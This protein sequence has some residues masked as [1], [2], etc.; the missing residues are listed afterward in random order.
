MPSNISLALTFDDVLLE[1]CYSEIL[2]TEVDPRTTLAGGIELSMPIISAAM[3]TVT[4]GNLAIAI[5]REG[6]LG[7]IHKN[8]SVEEQALEVAK[9]K[10]SESGM[11]VDP[12][13][14][15][16]KATLADARQLMKTYG[17]SGIPVVDESQKLVGILTNR[18]L[19]FESREELLVEALMTK[20]VVT[21]HPGTE[22]DAAMKLLHE[23][24][25]EKLPVVDDD[26]RLHGL[27]TIKDIEKSENFP[28]ATKDKLGRLR[29][30]GAVGVGG[31]R[32]DRVAALVNAGVDI[33]TIDTAHGHTK[34][35]LEAVKETKDA[36]PELPLVAGN[37]ATPEGARALFEA[38]RTS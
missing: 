3:D 12:V 36:Y 11:I 22:L 10:K 29:V 13:T 37:V 38:G 8:F 5:A 30:G 32:K 34:G 31:D 33:I 9:V 6:G 26:G 18:D 21:V 20:E 23:H 15:G 1:P 28:K 16:P 19:R 2:P 27:F 24:R 25:I 35:V 4:D 14:I 7:F 17:V